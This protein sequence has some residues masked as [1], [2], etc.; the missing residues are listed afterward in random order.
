VQRDETGRP[1]TRPP[2]V[3]ESSSSYIVVASYPFARK[4]S[5]ITSVSTV[6]IS[7]SLSLFLAVNHLQLFVTTRHVASRTANSGSNGS[8]IANA[9]VHANINGTLPKMI[10]IRGCAVRVFAKKFHIFR[11]M[12]NRICFAK[13]FGRK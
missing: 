10:I 1:Y 4:P 9:K 7:L 11:K 3:P 5:R 8:A 6:H 2:V 13:R 12:S